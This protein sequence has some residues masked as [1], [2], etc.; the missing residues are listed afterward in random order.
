MVRNAVE[1]MTSLLQPLLRHKRQASVLAGVMIV[2]L[3]LAGYYLASPLFIRTSLR[4]P[5]TT[6]QAAIVTGE[7]TSHGSFVGADAFHFGSGRALI[8]ETTSGR[9]A[10]RFE[11]FSVRN[12]PDLFVYLSPNADGYA[13]DAINLGRLKATDGNFNYEIPEGT[14]LSRIKSVVVWCRQFSTLFATAKL[15]SAS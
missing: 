14:D 10:L 6:S 2:I 12:G 13:P 9:H 1:F 4:E 3:G 5:E 7:I 15:S 8:Q 11:D